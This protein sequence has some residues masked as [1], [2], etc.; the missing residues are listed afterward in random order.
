MICLVVLLQKG[1]VFL[2]FSVLAV[3]KIDQFGIIRRAYPHMILCR[4]A[5]VDSTITVEQKRNY[6]NE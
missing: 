4:F 3:K 5:V 2:Q 6:Q 1:I